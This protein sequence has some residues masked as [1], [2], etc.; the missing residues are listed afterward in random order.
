MTHIQ[1]I[2]KRQSNC[3][4][5]KEAPRVSQ[6][7]QSGCFLSSLM[8]LGHPAN[9]NSFGIAQIKKSWSCCLA[10][11][12][13]THFPRHT[14]NTQLQTSSQEYPYWNSC[15]AFLSWSVGLVEPQMEF[16]LKMSQIERSRSCCLGPQRTLTY[17][18]AD[19]RFQ[20]QCFWGNQERFWGW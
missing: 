4:S 15:G 7:K 20:R 5:K 8:G 18:D 13:D 1:T 17:L 16:P 14:H 3:C 6:L 12:K 10:L 11:T 2:T 9:K 19:V